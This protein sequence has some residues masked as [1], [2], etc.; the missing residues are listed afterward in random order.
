MPEPIYNTKKGGPKMMIEKQDIKAIGGVLLVV[1]G[2]SL[3]FAVTGLLIDW[4]IGR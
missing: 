1:W 3:L 4:I 2:T